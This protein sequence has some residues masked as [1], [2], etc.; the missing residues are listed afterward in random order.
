MALTEEIR[1]NIIRELQCKQ[2]SFLEKVIKAISYGK[3]NAYC[4]QRDYLVADSYIGVIYRY[5]VDNT[6]NCLTETEICAVIDSAYEI[7]DESCNCN[8]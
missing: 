4:L 1:Y 3:K 2:A 8:C 7:L 6:T 5:D